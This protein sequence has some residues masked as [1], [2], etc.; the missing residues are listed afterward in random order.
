MCV[1]TA[2]GVIFDDLYCQLCAELWDFISERAG[3]AQRFSPKCDVCLFP[4]AVCHS[5]RSFIHQGPHSTIRTCSSLMSCPTQPPTTALLCHGSYTHCTTPRRA[6]PNRTAPHRITALCRTTL[7][8]VR[9]QL[10]CCKV[11]YA[12]A[13]VVS[14]AAMLLKAQ[15]FRQQLQERQSELAALDEPVQTAQSRQ[16]RKHRKRLLKTT[17]TIR[18]TYS[19]MMIGIAECIPLG[20]LQGMLH[21]FPKS[22]VVLACCIRLGLLSSFIMDSVGPKSRQ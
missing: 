19:S 22:P 10:W 6:V 20:I 5:L 12:I 16:L 2:P 8:C 17:R 1:V 21:T 11:F 4:P 15:V 7:R 3:R 13:T 9:A 18:M 14:V